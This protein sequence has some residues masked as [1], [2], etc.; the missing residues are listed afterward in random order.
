MDT[1]EGDKDALGLFAQ[2]TK[3]TKYKAKKGYVLSP[4]K[5]GRSSKI[6]KV[7]TARSILI[8]LPAAQGKH[9]RGSCL[10]ITLV[11]V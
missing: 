6:Q 2:K 3:K 5:H 7:Q 4:A 10:Y 11:S 1:R 9:D 8:L